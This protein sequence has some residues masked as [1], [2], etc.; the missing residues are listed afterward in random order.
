M[1]FFGV[2]NVGSWKGQFGSEKMLKGS[3]IKKP[4]DSG[5]VIDDHV[6]YLPGARRR[7]LA[8][9]ARMLIFAVLFPNSSLVRCSL[10]SRVLKSP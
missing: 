4:L 8:S 7:T 1:W 9:S 2:R 6:F 10:S 3:P 5:A